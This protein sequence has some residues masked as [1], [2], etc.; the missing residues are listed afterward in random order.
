M[1][2]VFGY[3]RGRLLYRWRLDSSGADMW[4]KSPMRWWLIRGLGGEQGGCTWV[5]DL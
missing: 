5:A 1:H 3:V 4:G 2:V